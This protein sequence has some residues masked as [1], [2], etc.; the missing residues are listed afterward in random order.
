MAWEEKY[1]KVVNSGGHSRFFD[2]FMLAVGI[3]SLVLVAPWIMSLEG[4]RRTLKDILREV[5]KKRVPTTVIM[6]S[7]DKEPLNKDSDALFRKCP[8]V[9]LHYN[10]SLH[11]KIYVCKCDP[12]GFALVGSA[13]LSGRATR[14]LEVGLLVEGRGEGRGVIDELEKLGTNHVPNRSSTV[15]QQYGKR[16]FVR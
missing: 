2:R 5:E 14:E 9:T 13:N 4:E 11:A 7:P 3:T 8:L 10:N 6:R 12:Y 1:I 16:T 15:C